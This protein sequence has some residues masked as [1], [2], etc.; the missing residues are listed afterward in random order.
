MG[1]EKK[2]GVGQ[3][4]F[5]DENSLKKTLRRRR[6]RS[7]KRKQAAAQTQQTSWTRETKKTMGRG[8]V[9]TG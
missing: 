5:F 7:S 3:H 2:R 8:H 9:V 6:R 1:G 4:V